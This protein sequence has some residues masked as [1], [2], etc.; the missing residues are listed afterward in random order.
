VVALNEGV[1]RRKALWR[2][3]GRSELEEN[4]AKFVGQKADG[5]RQEE[6]AKHSAAIM[7]H[8]GFCPPKLSSLPNRWEDL[9]RTP[10]LD[11]KKFQ[12]LLAAAHILQ[13]CS[14]RRARESNTSL[15]AAAVPQRD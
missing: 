9:P 13:E 14:D 10:V 2:P 1:R 15:R 12:Q 3:A 7:V 4:R 5:R 6:L 8:R 11:E